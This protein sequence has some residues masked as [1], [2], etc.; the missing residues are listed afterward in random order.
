MAKYCFITMIITQ[1]WLIISQHGNNQNL[2]KKQQQKVFKR[3]KE[4]HYKIQLASNLK[5]SHINL[6]H[7]CL[8]SNYVDS[9]AM[10]IFYF[11]FVLGQHV[12]GTIRFA[13]ATNAT[14]SMASS[15]G[16]CSVYLSLM[17]MADGTL[18]SCL[19]KT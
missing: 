12:A 11:V 6:T 3:K 4:L 19:W 17:S 18:I 14:I 2:W 15:M 16:Q 13:E 10:G 5:K 7:G 8:G 9:H 1:V